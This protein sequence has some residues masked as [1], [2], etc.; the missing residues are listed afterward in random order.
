MFVSNIYLQYYLLT[1]GGTISHTCVR[2]GS[3]SK[4]RE[5]HRPTTIHTQATIVK[6][7]QHITAPITRIIINL[8]TYHIDNGTTLY[9]LLHHLKK[10]EQ[11]NI[12]K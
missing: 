6:R 7:Q 5:L 4:G 1:R 8:M 11:Q 3:P 2:L 9:L 12:N 10:K